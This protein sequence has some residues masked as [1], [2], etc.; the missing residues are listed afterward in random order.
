M[1]QYAKYSEVRDILAQLFPAYTGRRDV[2]LMTAE[3]VRLSGTY[4]EG[5]RRDVYAAFD[6]ISR[7][8][9]TLPRFD[10]PQFGG[11]IDTP[12]I[13][14]SDGQGHYIVIVCWS[15]GVNYI[16]FFVHPDNKTSLLPS[17]E[18]ATLNDLQAAWLGSL[19]SLTS[20][21]RKDVNARYHVPVWLT[22]VL[23]RELS[24]YGMVT[25]NKAGAVTP[26]LKGK[27]ARQSLNSSDSFWYKW[28]E[29]WRFCDDCKYRPVEGGIARH[30]LD[31][32]KS[33]RPTR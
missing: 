11:P 15:Q 21:G 27:N 6:P 2:L 25:I 7:K 10:P 33:K 28:G 8:S 16:T 4:W 23:S 12:E 22:D 3:I 19:C 5:G 32:Y 9:V 29:S 30:W 26:T 1:T 18:E 13:P 31:E 20:A 17:S 14:L 24:D